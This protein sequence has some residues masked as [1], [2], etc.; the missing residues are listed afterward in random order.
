MAQYL[1]R[2]TRFLCRKSL[3]KTYKTFP[4]GGGSLPW[5]APGLC[6]NSSRALL[7]SRHFGGGFF[8]KFWKSSSEP[9]AVERSVKIEIGQAPE[10]RDWPIQYALVDTCDSLWLEKLDGMKFSVGYIDTKPLGTVH[11]GPTVLLLHGTPGSHRDFLPLI[12]PLVDR[13]V[14]VIAVNFPGFGVTRSAL[15]SSD[16]EDVFGQT[17]EEKTQFVIDFLSAINMKRK[18]SFDMIVGQ[19]TASVIAMNLMLATPQEELFKSLTLIS[20]LPISLP[21]HFGEQQK[22]MRLSSWWDTPKFRPFVSQ[23]IEY[24]CPVMAL[25]STDRTMWGQALRTLAA[26]VFNNVRA[27]YYSMEILSHPVLAVYSLNDPYSEAE[28]IQQTLNNVGLTQSK[29]RVYDRKATIIQRDEISADMND[30]VDSSSSSSIVSTGGKYRK[31]LAFTEGGH[32]PQDK[33]SSEIAD[34]LMTVLKLVTEQH[35]EQTTHSSGMPR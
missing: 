6:P 29:T 19:G 4:V 33:Y 23:Y 22:L 7:C 25:R 18:N 5:G 35:Y 26:V 27:Y 17:T 20:P 10:C 2:T 16:D 11:Y 31:C 9:V 15:P 24:E 8:S 14:R 13:G 1:S 21:Q 30:T 12:S 32:Y 34:E 28:Q 3:Q